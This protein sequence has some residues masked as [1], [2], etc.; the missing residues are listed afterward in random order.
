MMV[1]DPQ[2]PELARESQDVEAP[3]QRVEQG[4]H[5]TGR[6]MFSPPFLSS[7]NPYF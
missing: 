2:R 3:P 5:H 6:G 1:N 7:V 4:P